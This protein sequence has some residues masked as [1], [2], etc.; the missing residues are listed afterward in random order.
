MEMLIDFIIDVALICVRAAVSLFK[1]DMKAR[2]TAKIIRAKRR[3]KSRAL[4]NRKTIKN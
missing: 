2:K 3:E 1:S 4:L